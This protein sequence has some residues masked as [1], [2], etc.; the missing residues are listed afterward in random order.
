MAALL[1]LLVVPASAFTVH[2]VAK[3]ASVNYEATTT[4]SYGMAKQTVNGGNV[5]M[6]LRYKV[7]TD[8]PKLTLTL[9]GGRVDFT[10]V[11]NYGAFGLTSTTGGI[12][13]RMTYIVNDHEL[14]HN[15]TIGEG[16]FSDTMSVGPFFHYNLD[17]GGLDVSVT[18]VM[19]KYKDVVNVTLG[20]G[21]LTNTANLLEVGYSYVVSDASKLNYNATSKITESGLVHRSNLTCDL[22]GYAEM[23]FVTYNGTGS[24]NVTG[25]GNFDIG[26]YYFNSSYFS[27]TLAGSLMTINGY[28]SLT[29]NA[30][31]FSGF[32]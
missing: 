14:I 5:N 17:T 18:H 22:W 26:S 10:N 13:V 27:G 3:G 12:N 31:W 6:D 4:T 16:V 9:S 7:T 8:L 24:V 23:D 29:E 2:V 30:T 19:N 20:R 11:M 28:G 15:A 25:I 21:E 32:P 1:G